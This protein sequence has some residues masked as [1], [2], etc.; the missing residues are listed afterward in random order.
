MAQYEAQHNS[1]GGVQVSSFA[2]TRVEL[3]TI[4]VDERRY[5]TP[6]SLRIAGLLDEVFVKR[7]RNHPYYVETRP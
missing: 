1:V 6:P 3:R 4:Q 2:V 5:L 7:R